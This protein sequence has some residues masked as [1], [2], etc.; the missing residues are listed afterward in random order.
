MGEKERRMLQ[1]R[2]VDR[3]EW[4]GRVSF[5]QSYL[6]NLNENLQNLNQKLMS[7]AQ[8]V[9]VNKNRMFVFR[10]NHSIEPN[11]F[12]IYPQTLSL[13]DCKMYDSRL[14]LQ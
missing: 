10:A 11:R 13:R 12:Y 8:A 3:K 2:R 5:A 4:E 6:P 14:C 7:A 9:S 1:G